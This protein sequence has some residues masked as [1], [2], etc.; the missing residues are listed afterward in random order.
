[1]GRKSRLYLAGSTEATSAIQRSG[2]TRR[3]YRI[4]NAQPTG[5]LSSQ[6]LRFDA[7]IDLQMPVPTGAQ[8][9][10]LSAAVKHEF[11]RNSHRRRRPD[12]KPL[13][14]T[15]AAVRIALSSVWTLT[16]CYRAWYFK[17]T[18]YQ[19]GNYPV[20][21]LQRFNTQPDHQTYRV[22]VL[23]ISKPFPLCSRL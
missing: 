18:F 16:T 23:K 8:L 2:V 9:Q 21:K 4:W 12:S 7:G 19:L 10:I 13:T 20:S 15:G 1:M 5:R 22:T 3:K 11:Q 14:V 17:H 6:T